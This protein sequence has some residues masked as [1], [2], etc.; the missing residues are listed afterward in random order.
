MLKRKTIGKIQLI[1]GIIILLIG[2]AGI[3]Y[4]Y[5]MYHQFIDKE[6]K[7]MQ[8]GWAQAFNY[9]KNFSNE[10]RYI[11]TFDMISMYKEDIRYLTEIFIIGLGFIVLLIIVSL[12]LVL[13]GLANISDKNKK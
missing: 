8:E 13:E 1:L 10:T 12:I 3:V 5:A 2:L 7:A 11:A 9:T 6:S 4:C